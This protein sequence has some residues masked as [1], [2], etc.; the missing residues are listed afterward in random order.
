MPTTPYAPQ[1]PAPQT[2]GEE[3][4]GQADLLNEENPPEEPK[5]GG[6]AEKGVIPSAPLYSRVNKRLEQLPLP[7]NKKK[8]RKFL[9]LTGYCHLWIEL[10]AQKSILL[11]L[12]LL[13]E[14]L[15][16]LIW[17]E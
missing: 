3:V 6:K 9:G 11:Y 1:R 14:E 7:K 8:L 13:E 12:K 15:N 10:Y 4:G 17:A 5:G 2:E 16:M